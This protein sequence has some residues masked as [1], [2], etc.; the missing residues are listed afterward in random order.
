MKEIPV[1]VSDDHICHHGILGMKWGVR[2]FQNADGTLTAK[3]KARMNDVANSK[4]KSKINT[5]LARTTYKY[6]A[7]ATGDMS[8]SKARESVK[9][10][11]KASKYAKGS[12]KYD[13]LMTKSKDAA[14]RAKEFAKLSDEATKKVRD[15]DE[16][17]LK[18]GRDFI[19]QVDMNV[20]LTKIPA[21]KAIMND[22]NNPRVGEMSRMSIL[23][24]N[25]YKVIEK[26]NNN[27]STSKEVNRL[28]EEREKIQKELKS[29]YDKGQH[30]DLHTHYKEWDEQVSDKNWDNYVNKERE[31][32]ALDKKLKEIEN[33]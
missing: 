16:G 32:K 4:I 26:K 5:S 6:N 28:K 12:A 31:L 27:T 24:Y 2:R 22:F 3:G 19:V 9:L 15:I 10:E 11:K 33:S 18:A 8:T 21:W 7:K 1:K 23:G 25:D 20:N 14:K 29:I 17:K 30:Y 13:E